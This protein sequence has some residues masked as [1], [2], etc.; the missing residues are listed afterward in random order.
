MLFVITIEPARGAVNGRKVH[1][2]RGLARA[3]VKWWPVV[4][5][6]A[7]MNELTVDF[8]GLQS[9]L[10]DLGSVMDAAECHG[11]LSGHACTGQP[12]NP[13]DFLPQ[14]VVQ[15]LAPELEKRFAAELV[16]LHQR[17]RTEL[18]EA[19]LAFQLLLPDDDEEIA[20]RLQSLGEWCQGFL[21]G[22]TVAGVS[23]DSGYSEDFAEILADFIEIG[24]AG[25]YESDDSEEDEASYM[26]LVEHVRMGV[27][28]LVEELREK[29]LPPESRQLH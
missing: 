10:M 1:A 20:W 14:L 9:L 17:I 24:Q 3:V 27:F 22:I 29:G 26:E 19:M 25:D 6:Q 2:R 15:E 7:V 11:M 12:F 21:Y 28:L 13:A 5:E 16:H 18:D 4:N 8:D 23:S